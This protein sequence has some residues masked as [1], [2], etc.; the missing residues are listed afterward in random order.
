MAVVIETFDNLEIAQSAAVSYKYTPM[1]KWETYEEGKYSEN[2]KNDDANIR[3][4][5]SKNDLYN[6]IGNAGVIESELVYN[7]LYEIPDIYTILTE[8]N[9]IIKQLGGAHTF[10][11]EFRTPAEAIN[12]FIETYEKYV[13]QM[14]TKLDNAAS[15]ID[16]LT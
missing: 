2:I 8:N 15:I 4:Q 7:K 14:N 3:Q 12:K 16:K 6:I 5:P 13:A 10:S 9:W 11:S 1:E